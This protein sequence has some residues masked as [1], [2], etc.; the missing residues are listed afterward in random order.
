MY[1]CLCA[2][3]LPP[4]PHRLPRKK[5]FIYSFENILHIISSCLDDIKKCLCFGLQQMRLSLLSR[6][7]AMPVALSTP[8]QMG[9]NSSGSAIGLQ[10]ESKYCLALAVITKSKLEPREKCNS[11]RMARHRGGLAASPVCLFLSPKGL[12]TQ[13]SFTAVRSPG[14]IQQFAN[15][16]FMTVIDLFHVWICHV[17]NLKSKN[18]TVSPV[19]KR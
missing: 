7:E 10:S 3:G 14:D 9:G 15:K 1:H 6:F 16:F 11:G 12:L 13:T 2:R 17:W 4:P 19:F 5:V 18:S 8:T